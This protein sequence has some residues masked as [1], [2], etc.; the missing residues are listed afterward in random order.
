VRQRFLPP[1]LKKRLF[2]PLYASFA[3]L[4]FLLLTQEGLSLV[5]SVLRQRTVTSVNRTLEIKRES[6]RLLK[7]TLEEKVALRGY[8]LSQDPEFLAQYWAGRAAFLESFSQISQLVQSD[9]TLEDDLLL[10]KTFHDHWEIQFAQPVLS[11]S[12]NINAFA[13]Q[14]SL[15]TLRTAVNGILTYERTILDR[16]YERLKQLNQLNRLELGLSSLNIVLIIVGSGLNFILLRRRVVAPLRHLMTVG[17]AWR[18]GHL[19]VQIDHQSEDEMGV[20]T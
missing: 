13:E 8:L 19:G 11:G 1:F 16:E 5:V 15:D 4:I 2:A 20:V 7:A 17:R 6:E 14:D 9:A 12:F 3:V 10:I 18:T